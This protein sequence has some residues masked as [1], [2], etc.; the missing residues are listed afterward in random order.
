MVYECIYYCYLPFYIRKKASK[1]DLDSVVFRM[2][3]FLGSLLLNNSEE[4][5]MTIRFR[6]TYL[7]GSL[8]SA[9]FEQFYM[10]KVLFPDWWHFL[11][12]LLSTG[13]GRLYMTK[14]LLRY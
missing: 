14:N 3:V 6:M 4:F 5:Y 1:L 7:L 13:F 11:G 8:P 12:S 2:M 9:V 10:T